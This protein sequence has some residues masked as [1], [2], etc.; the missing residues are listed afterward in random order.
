MA[1]GGT[2]PIVPPG[3][4]QY[5]VPAAAATQPQYLPVVLGAARIHFTD[6]KLGIDTVRDVLCAAPIGNGAVPVDWQQARELEVTTGDLEREPAADA[7]FADLP[8]A[9]LQPRNYPAWEKSFGRWVAHAQRIECLRHRSTKLISAPDEGERDF[10]ARVQDAR[11][12]AR[13]AEVEAVRTK[14][15]ARR[16]TLAERLRRAEEGITRE[17]QQA[18]QQ[19]TQTMLSM[20]AAALGALFGR[21]AIS[22]GTLGRATTAA[23]G[24]GRSMK[25]AEDVKRAEANAAAAREKLEAFDQ[26]VSDELK[27]IAAGYDGPIELE[28]VALAPKRGQV[29]VQ[30]VALGWDPR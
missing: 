1:T 18:S 26:R 28:R 12:A 17:E 22:T 19:K 16:E 23:R 10:R 29:H 9:A 8:A 6:A 2:R 25:E 13:D 4:D 5:F 21:K 14:F 24:M 3:I 7:V 11:R 27:E 30:F 20:G 15:A